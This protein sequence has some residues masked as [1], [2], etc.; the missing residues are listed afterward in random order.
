MKMTTAHPTT[1]CP[2]D[3]FCGVNMVQDEDHMTDLEKKHVPVVC[4]PSSVKKGECFE[5]TIEVGKHMAHPNE[6]S[7]YIE[8]IELYADHT[9]LA[10][11]DFTAQTTHPTVK[12]CLSLDHVHSKLRA[13]GRCNIHGLWEGHWPIQVVE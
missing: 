8:F 3:L 4:G 9:Y 10:R 1:K 12:L 2:E 7:H 6:L 5:V 13:F 11:I